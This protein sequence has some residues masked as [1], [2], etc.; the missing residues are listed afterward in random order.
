MFTNS[1]PGQPDAAFIR[2]DDP[3]D[4]DLDAAARAGYLIRTRTDEP[5]IDARTN[6]TTRRDRALA[7]GAHFLSTDY[8]RPSEYFDSAYVVSLPSGGVA[9]C[10]PVTAPSTCS[11]DQLAE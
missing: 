8:Y 1:T 2:F 4:P 3:S 9:R 7:S 11:D 5:T 10:N 6:D